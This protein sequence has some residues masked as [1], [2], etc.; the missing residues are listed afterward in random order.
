MWNAVW[1]GVGSYKLSLLAYHIGGRRIVVSLTSKATLSV[2]L[3][4]RREEITAA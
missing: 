3:S 4:A 1:P 2:I